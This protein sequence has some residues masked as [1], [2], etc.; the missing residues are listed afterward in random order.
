MDIKY[1]RMKVYSIIIGLCL[2]F[3]MPGCTPDNGN[4]DYIKLNEATIGGIAED[5][6]VN[7]FANLKIEPDLT[8]SQKEGENFRYLWY[9]FQNT[10]EKID[11]LGY[12]RNLDAKVS[13]LPGDYALMFKVFDTEMGVYYYK[14]TD[15]T[16]K[17]VLS[18]GILI[19]GSVDDSVNISMVNTEGVVSKNIYKGFTGKYL[20]KN[21]ESIWH[22]IPANSGGYIGREY[23][24]VVYDGGQAALFD[25]LNF[26]KVLEG[27]QM[28][29]IT[30]DVVKIEGYQPV[31]GRADYLIN[32]GKLHHRW[33]YLEY[34]VAVEG[35][36]YLSKVPVGG[37]NRTD[38]LIC[39]YDEA[40]R[41]FIT[42]DDVTGTAMKDI[43]VYKTPNP[44]FDPSDV[45]LDIV[46]VFNTDGW[47]TGFFRD[48]DSKTMY[49]L[50]FQLRINSN[51]TKISP[52]GKKPI[53]A[54]AKLN[55]AKVM[56]MHESDQGNL[57]FAQ[58]GALWL[59][60]IYSS[61]EKLLIDFNRDGSNFEVVKLM[62]HGE[63]EIVVALNDQDKQSDGGEVRIL[64]TGLL[65]GVITLNEK[66]GGRYD[67]LTDRIVDIAYKFMKK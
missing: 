14:R 47:C 29:A 21:P 3:W 42:M 56:L 55:N 49:L 44:A 17:D 61:E 5:Y 13:V 59:Y 38:D 43:Q 33:Y 24:T 8:F 25:P 4:Y 22:F 67:K 65:G 36:Y 28:F 50:D 11:T 27:P 40:G 60:D 18:E 52:K 66:A 12:S 16:V 19:L 58:A 6:V 63:D 1:K 26:I 9:L 23:V 46:Y 35:D 2:S 10:S 37:F 54:E 39:F 7:R 62:L 57:I 64:Q 48:P 30:P 32:H 34:N 53:P 51:I 41:R 31:Y 15:I 20:G 45:G